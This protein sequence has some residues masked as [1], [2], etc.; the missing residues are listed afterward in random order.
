MFLSQSW[1]FS[2]NMSWD[3]L[4]PFMAQQKAT[5]SN[6]NKWLGVHAI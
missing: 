5:D 1:L 3:V 4:F 2:Y 6:I